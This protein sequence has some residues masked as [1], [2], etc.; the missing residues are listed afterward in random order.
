MQS[1]NEPILLTGATGFLGSRVL[2]QL[3]TAEHP[4]IVLVRNPSKLNEQA[5]SNNNI[6]V[7]QGDFHDTSLVND[8]IN[9]LRPNRI[10]HLAW[11][12]VASGQ[13]N[14]L[15]QIANLRSSLSMLEQAMQ[16]DVQSFLAIGSQAEYGHFNKRVL[17]AD[18]GIPTSLYGET[19]L[20]MGSVGN[21]LCEK[22]PI[23]FIWMRLFSCYGP[24]DRE[25]ALIPYVIRE[26]LH[27]RIPRLTAGTQLW[28][29]L[30]VDDAAIAIL[31]A[32]FHPSLQ[33]IVN[34]GSGTTVRIKQVIELI[35]DQVS[36]GKELPFGSIQTTSNSLF[37][38]EA[39][40]DKLKLS[41]WEPRTELTDGI[42][43]TIAAIRRQFNL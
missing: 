10:L 36:P 29:Y 33:G 11:T 38:L 34:L 39:G 35:R 12:G 1:E 18:H 7:I 20:A 32:A 9:R 25:E 27:D 3:I 41:G 8:I 31:H 16:Y 13:R 4:T 14:D 15:I 23:R 40:I 28:D 24:G 21:R 37:H 19:K 17:E 42:T 5:R 26:L 43:Q 22:G 6:D 30:F 2:D